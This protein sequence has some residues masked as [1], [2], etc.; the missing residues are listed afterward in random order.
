MNTNDGMDCKRIECASKMRLPCPT[1]SLN[2]KQVH[3][4]RENAL[5]RDRIMYTIDGADCERIE[6]TSHTCQQFHADGPSR[7]Q[8]RAM[9]DHA[10]V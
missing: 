10:F 9:H 2:R 7:K 4:M 8:A 3:A 5:V 6:R 1:D